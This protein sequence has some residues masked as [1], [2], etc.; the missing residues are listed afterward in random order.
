MKN[1]KLKCE[2]VSPV[3]IG[4]GQ[5]TEPLSYVIKDDRLYRISFEKFINKLNSSEIEHFETLIDSGDLIKIREF[6]SNY[7]DYDGIS[8]Y[9]VQVTPY[10]RENYYSKLNKIENRLIINTFIR[11]AHKPMIPGSSIK[12]AVRTALLSV[13]ASSRELPYP[14]GFYE[15]N[16]FEGEILN[17]KNAK[18]DPFRAVRF[19]DSFLDNQDTIVRQILNVTKKRKASLTSNKMEIVNEISHST[20]TGNPVYFENVLSIDE[21]LF[22]TKYFNRKLSVE[23]I[24][25]ACKIFYRDKMEMEHKK[26]YRGGESERPSSIIL[27]TP[28][29]ENEAFIRIGRFSG[30]ESVTLDKY[31]NPRPPG[32]KSVWGTS[33]NLAEGV[34]PMG[35]VKVCFG[36]AKK[37]HTANTA[38]DLKKNHNIVINKNAAPADLSKLKNK[39]KVVEKR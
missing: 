38:H 6:I 23:E 31:R 9:S 24:I 14:K 4:S 29:E 7:E 39:F 18:N 22:E 12:G 17:F 21:K 27:D 3:H 10:V 13:V 5:E 30:V 25:A 32:K 19:R 8:L 28:L 35:W 16:Q 2:I 1:I 36:G 34:Y 37:A 33:R 15:Q 20:I 11:S 26:F